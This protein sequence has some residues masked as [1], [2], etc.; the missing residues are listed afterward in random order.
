MTTT[1]VNPRGYKFYL[2][3][4]VDPETV[5]RIDSIRGEVPRSRVVERALQQFLETHGERSSDK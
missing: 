2:G 5:E 4:T 3:A 1:M